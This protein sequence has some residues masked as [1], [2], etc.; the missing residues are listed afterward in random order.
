MESYVEIVSY[1]R[2]MCEKKCTNDNACE[3]SA[4]SRFFYFDQ[5]QLYS[6]IPSG[7][8]KYR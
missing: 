4:R 1:I 5:V 2:N 6:F 3:S 8:S 7:G